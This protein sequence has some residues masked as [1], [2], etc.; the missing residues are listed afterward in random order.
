[1]ENEYP[2]GCP[3]REVRA[4][5]GLQVFWTSGKRGGFQVWDMRECWWGSGACVVLEQELDKWAM[6][7]LMF[8]C[9]R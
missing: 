5:F 1:M 9:V 2:D 8:G 7:C 4:V 3:D 6:S